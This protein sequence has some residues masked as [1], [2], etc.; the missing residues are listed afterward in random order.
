VNAALLG[1]IRAGI[2]T[3]L[4][5]SGFAALMLVSC[6][7]VG[8]ALAADGEALPSFLS[9]RGVG[10]PTSMFGT[11]VERG[12]LL[13][14]PFFE[15]YRDKDAEYSPQELGFDNPNDFRGRYRA[16]EGLIFLGY[17]LTE[18][19][20]LELEAAVIDATQDKAS[21]DPSTMPA[22]LSESGLGDVQ[23]Q[24]DFR[25]L[26]ETESRPEA[27]SYLEVVYP[28]NKDKVLIGTSDWEFKF[29]TGVV[30]GFGWGTLTGRVAGEY[31]RAE[32][33]AELGEMAV[34]YLK[35]LSPSWRAY[36]GVE[37]TQDE[38]ELITEM[39]WHLSR[40][41]FVKL[42]SAFGLTSK[43]TDWA[44]EIGVMFRF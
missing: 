41:A 12:E 39:Q 15:H 38:V 1:A 26:R 22:S 34:E 37:G 43:A 11:Y 23:T 10:I 18:N 32:K 24:F 44:P 7:G 20:A 21:D 25:W 33:K 29:G 16:S 31:S 36:L 3:A 30:K 17:G 27:F 6:P 42:N 5:I 28:L 14:Y 4:A 13:V 2:V 8:R 35:R 40:R 9:D 19:L